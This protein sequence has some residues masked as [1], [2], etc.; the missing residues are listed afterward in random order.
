MFDVNPD[1]HRYYLT[2]LERQMQPRSRPFT[3]KAGRV[4]LLDRVRAAPALLFA[5]CFILGGFAG[6]TLL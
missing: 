1:T 5:A 6:G 4:A 2:D 3:G